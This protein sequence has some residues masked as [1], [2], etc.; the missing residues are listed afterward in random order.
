MKIKKIDLKNIEQNENSRVIYKEADLSELMH[1]LKN[2]GLLQP[3]GVKDLG[4]GKYEAV[5]G[6]RRIMAARKLGWADID[7]HVVEAV[8]DNERDILNLLEN[9]KR[10]NTTVSEDGRIFQCLRDRGLTI[11][12]ISARVGIRRERVEMALEVFNDVP[13]EFKKKIVNRVAGQRKK[14]GQI[15]ATAAHAVMQL[16]RQHNLNR[17]QFRDL[18]IFASKPDT[19]VTHVSHI[20]PLVKEG[21]TIGEAVKAVG[22]MSRVVMYVFI[23]EDRIKKLEK[24]HG[25]SITNILWEQLE[26]NPELGVK[27]MAGGIKLPGKNLKRKA[28]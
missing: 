19:S 10:T 12:E 20:A 11:D 6:N 23:E 24:K 21:F 16:R 9:L 2:N 4:N 8:D 25:Q 28:S 13:A 3:V 15:S 27:R 26:K 5:F 22:R 7:A 14:E 1:T 18:M 17:R